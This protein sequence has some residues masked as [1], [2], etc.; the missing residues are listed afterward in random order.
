MQ[1][2]ITV[3][4]NFYID[5]VCLCVCLHQLIFLFFPLHLQPR[6]SV[7]S[8]FNSV[9]Q[10]IVSLLHLNREAPYISLLYI[11]VSFTTPSHEPII[12]PT[13]GSAS[14]AFMDALKNL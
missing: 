4:Y 11:S 10:T 14:A 7:S 6:H 1:K 5:F 9:I 13:Y 8:P 12:A 3:S 2:M